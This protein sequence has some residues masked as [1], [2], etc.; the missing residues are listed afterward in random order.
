MLRKLFN[1]VIGRQDDGFR[2]AADDK[3]LIENVRARLVLLGGLEHPEGT[4]L[5]SIPGAVVKFLPM[6][7]M[8]VATVFTTDGRPV[9]SVTPDGEIVYVQATA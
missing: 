7:G 1:K 3:E 2:P 9:G 4:V 6:A 8:T 5:R